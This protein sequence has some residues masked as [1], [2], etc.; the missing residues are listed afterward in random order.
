MNTNIINCAVSWPCLAS[1]YSKL[2]CLEER[3]NYQ[4]WVA[5]CN[6][7]NLKI[8][9]K[10]VDL[11]NKK[12]S[13]E[14]ILQEVQLIK[15]MS[16]ENILTFH[17][18]F[19]FDAQL[20]LI[21]SFM[22]KGSCSRILNLLREKNPKFQGLNETLISYILSEILKGLNY[23]HE[24]GHIHSAIRPENI[25]MDRFG[26]VA[27]A[28]FRI[29]E[30]T[31]L[32][33]EGINIDYSYY[34]APEYLISKNVSECDNRIDI[35]S[36]GITALEL[37]TGFNPLLELDTY[38]ILEIVN[39]DNIINHFISQISNP[40]EFFSKNFDD[41]F[42]KCL[43][44]ISQNR[45][46]SSELLKHRFLRV[47]EKE[48]L[49]LFLNSVPDV[50]QVEESEIFPL[51]ETLESELASSSKSNSNNLKGNLILTKDEEL[52]ISQHE[53]LGYAP[54]TSWVFDSD[55]LKETHDFSFHNIV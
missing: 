19:V 39:N 17:C 11:E 30:D 4:I 36:L 23:L 28:D 13:I 48:S 2:V 18:S 10:I 24:G 27:L 9:L 43:Q 21:S 34:M 53:K 33:S 7:N 25:L 45:P 22:D 49:I 47:R 12:K 3:F 32:D 54:G 5:S 15:L 6:E 29:I 1:S 44:K 35:W 8:S 41:F 50:D 42:K 46:S 16:H 20:W 26:H 14:D 37:A 52:F 40:G 38:E 55:S 31:L 51:E